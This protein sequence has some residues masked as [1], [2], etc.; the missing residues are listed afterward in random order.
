M[1]K[2]LLNIFTDATNRDVDFAKVCTGCGVAVFFMLSIY[3][4]GFRGAPWNPLDWA[5]ALGVMVGA[6]AGISKVK[7][8]SGTKPDANS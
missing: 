1:K 7:D 3:D 5:G 4:Y 8:S 2:L 6:G